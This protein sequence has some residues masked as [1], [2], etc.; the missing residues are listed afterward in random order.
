[1]LNLVKLLAYLPLSWLQAIGRFIGVLIYLYPSKYR[2]RLRRNARQAG[3]DDP[4]FRLRAA[5]QAG[6]M[7]TEIPKVWWRTESCLAKTFS[8]DE[9]IVKQ[10]IAENKG[11]LYLTPHLGCFEI[12]ARHL[13]QYGPLTVMF[14]P[15]RSKLLDPIV[16]SARDM[17]NLHAVPANRKGVKEFV[18]ALKRGEAVGMLPDQ[19]PREGDGIWLPVFGRYALTMTLAARLAIQTGV[20]IILTAGERL[21]NGKG[22]RIHY[23]RLEEPLPNQADELAAKINQALETLIRRFPEQYIWSYNRYK[24]PDHAPLHP[25]ESN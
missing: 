14:R 19:V 9:H 21:P 13:T 16:D 3:Y 10:A 2:K 25:D 5:A 8:P 22:W 17:H 6:A 11:I 7:I 24:E 4:K 1:M 23:L 12:T 15:S 18:R 20:S